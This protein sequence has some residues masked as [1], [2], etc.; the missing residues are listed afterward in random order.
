MS[1]PIAST[2][3][4][5]PAFAGSDGVMSALTRTVSASRSTALRMDWVAAAASDATPVK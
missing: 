1:D 4:E 3:T 2:R 5:G